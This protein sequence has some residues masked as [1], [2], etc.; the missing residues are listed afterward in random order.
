MKHACHAIACDSPCPPAHLM[1]RKH[2]AMV[3]PETQSEVYRTVK[4]RGGGVNK[5]WAPWWRAQAEA[6]VE[7]AS[8]ENRSPKAIKKYR[9]REMHFA[10]T[11]E[12]REPR[13]DV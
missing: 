5:T 8:A 9:T 10:D 6:I 7:V 1:C 11:L 13:N 3:T 4:L 2:W 12:K